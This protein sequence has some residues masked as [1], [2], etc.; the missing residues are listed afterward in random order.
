VRETIAEFI[1]R[2]KAKNAKVD[3][4]RVRK[5]DESRRAD[6]VTRMLNRA[7]IAGRALVQKAA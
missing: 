2:M 7:D 6:N 3:D 4:E 5:D 1:E